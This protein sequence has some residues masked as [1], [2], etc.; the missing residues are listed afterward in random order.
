MGML[1]GKNVFLTGASKG[2]GREIARGLAKEGASIALVA[3]T[4]SALEE[5]A[6]EVEGLG[7]RG[8]AVPADVSDRAQVKEAVG[9]VHK[10][11]GDIHVLIS[12]A[13]VLDNEPIAGHSDEAWE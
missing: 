5:L 11:L 2:I 13:G 12:S 10:D 9:R 7:G 1:E 3:R 4:E 8:L 6:N